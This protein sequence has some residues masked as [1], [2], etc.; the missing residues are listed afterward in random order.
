MP[1]ERVDVID[2]CVHRVRTRCHRT[3][4]C[5]FAASPP[6]R[7]VPMRSNTSSPVSEAERHGAD[8]VAPPC[9]S[10]APVVQPRRAPV[11]DQVG[12]P[13]TR[14]RRSR[15]SRVLEP[16]RR[17][18]RR[19]ARERRLRRSGRVRRTIPL[20]DSVVPQISGEDLG[21]SRCP[22]NA[23]ASRGRPTGCL[24]RAR[25]RRRWQAE[26]RRRSRLPRGKRRWLGHAPRMPGERQ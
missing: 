5:R 18:G 4:G 9:G 8:E 10:T 22:P 26:R 25:S 3:G 23:R 16:R 7:R 14:C 20:D 1:G 2:A 11:A 21:P 12:V 15:S 6:R 13:T 17:A 19:P 24:R